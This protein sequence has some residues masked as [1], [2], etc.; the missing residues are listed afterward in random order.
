MFDHRNIPRTRIKMKIYMAI[1]YGVINW[2]FD[3]FTTTDQSSKGNSLARNHRLTCSLPKIQNIAHISPEQKIIAFVTIAYFKCEWFAFWNIVFFCCW[4]S[5]ILQFHFQPK[6]NPVRRF[7]IE[8]K[9]SVWM[10]CA[11]MLCRW[12]ENERKL[13]D[14][15]HQRHCIHFVRWQWQ[16]SKWNK[17]LSVLLMNQN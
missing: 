13:H 16:F 7:S 5:K 3:G 10:M 14:R 12:Q 8:M 2:T 15:W 17:P 6:R 1:F 11:V 4:I 9:I